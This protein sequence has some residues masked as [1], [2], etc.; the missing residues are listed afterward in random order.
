[1]NEELQHKIDE[2][3]R[4]VNLQN[5]RLT[6]LESKPVQLD[7]LLDNNS[8]N[9]IE[10]IISDRILDVVWNDYFYFH[11]FPE[12]V[13]GWAVAGGGASTGISGAGVTLQTGAVATNQADAGKLSLNQQI[14][15]YNE[16]GSFR[17]TF[18]TGSI[19]DVTINIGIGTPTTSNNHYG[20]RV[21]N[22]TLYGVTGNGT[23]E[24]TI[25]LGSIT[26][27]D[28][29]T[30]EARLYPGSR[31]DFYIS[32]IDNSNLKNKGSITTTIP[33]G[34][35]SAWLDLLIKTN[36]AA[37]KYIYVNYMEYIQKRPQ[38]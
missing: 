4:T 11:S 29:Y 28:A 33:S 25:T 7:R 3:S 24:T 31:V 13:D 34:L 36:T 32:D 16:V 21:I 20:F 12:S 6:T 26:A 37:S 8:K 30:L 23:S 17:T 35:I 15:T 19:A 18:E 10:D 1:M 5:D 14:H 27:N 38:K 9:T 22:S 2:L